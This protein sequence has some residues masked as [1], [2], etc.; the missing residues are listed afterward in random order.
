VNTK[1]F[2][3]D[4]EFF[5]WQISAFAVRNDAGG[6]IKGLSNSRPVA[7]TLKFL[8]SPVTHL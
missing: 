2:A 6:G 5:E 4:W 1:L 3:R 7:L 8:D